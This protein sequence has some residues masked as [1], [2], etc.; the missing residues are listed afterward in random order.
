MTGESEMRRI[1][2]RTPG[3]WITAGRFTKRSVQQASGGW[4]LR[5]RPIR[6]DA[7][8]NPKRPYAGP[9]ELLD[10]CRPHRASDYGGTLSGLGRDC[11]RPLRQADAAG[12]RLGALLLLLLLRDLALTCHSLPCLRCNLR[13]PRRPGRN[14]ALRRAT[15]PDTAALARNTRQRGHRGAARSAP[16]SPSCS[17]SAIRSRSARRG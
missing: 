1:R 5:N 14:S 4:L 17:C 10:S 2:Y 9:A 7:L 6:E 12:V 16:D 13:H 15:A 3:L 11:P 8:P